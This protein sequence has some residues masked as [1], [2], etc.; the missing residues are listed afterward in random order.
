M[1]ELPDGDTHNVIRQSGQ[2]V[3][4]VVPLRNTSNCA[5]RCKNSM[6]TRN[7]ML[8]GPGPDAP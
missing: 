5:R 4:V 8:P 6:S 1:S 3:A 7:S 2:L